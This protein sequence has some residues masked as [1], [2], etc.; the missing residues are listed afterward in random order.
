M[1]NRRTEKNISRNNG[2][3]FSKHNENYKLTDPRSP[4][5]SK[6]KKLRITPRHVVIKLLKISYKEKTLKST[7]G[8][9]TFC[10]LRKIRVMSDFSLETL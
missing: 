10:T 6:H 5:N 4:T 8:N 2:P 3:K 1:G 7:R 9:K